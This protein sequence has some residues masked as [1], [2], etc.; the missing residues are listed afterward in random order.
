M[1]KWFTFAAVVLVTAALL[2][3]FGVLQDI[4]GSFN[5]WLRWIGAK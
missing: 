5:T 4:G 2:W 3:R 1:M